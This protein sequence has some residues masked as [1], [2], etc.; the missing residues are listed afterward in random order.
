M[1]SKQKPPVVVAELGRPET[2]SETTSR[3]AEQSRLYKQ[4]KTVNNLVCSLLVSLGLV[5]VMVLVVPRGTDQW[6]SLIH[7]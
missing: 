5:R 3:K 7:I 6:L 4:R 1:A 2:P